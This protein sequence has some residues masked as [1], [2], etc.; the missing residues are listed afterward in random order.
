[1]SLLY[2]HGTINM[3]ETECSECNDDDKCLD[4]IELGQLYILELNNSAFNTLIEVNKKISKCE[5]C[6]IYSYNMHKCKECTINLIN[7]FNNLG[8]D[9]KHY[10]NHVKNCLNLFTEELL[11]GYQDAMHSDEYNN[12]NKYLDFRRQKAK[13]IAI[14]ISKCGNNKCICYIDDHYV[15]NHNSVN[16]DIE[17]KHAD[18]KIYRS[19]KLDE[20]KQYNQK[21]LERKKNQGKKSNQY[22]LLEKVYNK[23]SKSNIKENRHIS[24]DDKFVV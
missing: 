5:K 21:Y 2:N 15:D 14:K 8:F 11:Y 10:T 1:M 12:T 23:R 17:S 7:T 20:N 16:L 18:S 3:I 22:K 4:C 9:I 13:S 6:K 19:I 24:T